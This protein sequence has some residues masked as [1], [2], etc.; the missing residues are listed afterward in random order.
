[1][2]T[3]VYGGSLAALVAAE[4]IA[5]AGH[6]VTL[7]TPSPHLG[8]HFAGVQLGE[9]RFDAGLVIFEFGALNSEQAPDV[10]S[11][12]RD[13]RN[14]CG[15]F[16][17]VLAGYAESMGVT[18]SRIPR[19]QMWSER[20]LI[21]DFVFDTRVEG[22]RALPIWLREHARTEIDAIVAGG[23][24]PWH[25]RRKYREPG[26]EHLSYESASLA[27]HGVLLHTCFLEPFARKVTGRSSAELLALYSRAAWLP[28]FWPETLKRAFDGAT[29]LLPDMPF[30]VARAGAVSDLVRAI[31][32]R[33]RTHPSI[34]HK[35]A[36]ITGVHAARD[37]VDLT[38]ADGTLRA[39]R[40]VWGH[41]LDALAHAVGVPSAEEIERSRVVIAIATVARGDVA[42]PSLGTVMLPQDPALP[43]R[44]TNQSTNAGVPD[45]PF[46]RLSVEWGA[47]NAASDDH[48]LLAGTR[49]AL[50]RVGMT[51]PDAEFVQHKVLRIAR[52][53]VIPNAAN[54]ARI[55]RVRDDIEGLGLPL[56]LVAPSAGFGV[57]SLSDH[58]VQGL[59]VE[60]LVAAT[61]ETQVVAA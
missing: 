35:I 33:I 61:R 25:A 13:V 57:A 38:T 56:H 29:A 20:G 11:Y 7:V 28:L 51:A 55:V 37:G 23:E 42:D 34:D 26:Y 1:M 47:D 16:G 22:V 19:L 41:D 52:A 58:L 2:S 43:Y 9:A 4:R 10:A 48:A 8:G 3:M 14:D 18:L 31:A 27:N 59:Q 17:S 15:R 46:V 44:I 50:A 24:H 36:T 49:D 5:S 39:T 21:P 40:L 54:R 60:R 12:D 32:L 53:L 30:H 6:C 45:E